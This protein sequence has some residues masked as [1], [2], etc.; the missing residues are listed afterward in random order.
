MGEHAFDLTRAV[1]VSRPVQELYGFWRDPT[2]LP[3]AIKYIESVQMTGQN[4]AHW[5]VK[6]PLGPKIDLHIE[7]TED[8]RNHVIAWKSLPE[9]QIQTTGSLRFRPAP[10]NRGTQVYL[11]VGFDPPGG[12][13][14]EA[15]L[16]LFGE[17][18]AQYFSQYLREFKQLMETGEKATTEGQTSGRESEVQQ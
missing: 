7:L 13:I 9:S 17:A 18:P 4:R 5:T 2:H 15:L 16:K 10:A 8:E 11:T 12:A 14:G 1:T 3:E 6:P